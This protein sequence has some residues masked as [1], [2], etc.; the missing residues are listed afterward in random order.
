MYIP[1]LSIPSIYATCVY[2]FKVNHLLLD[3]QLLSSSLE[4]TVSPIQS[5]P[6]LSS[7]LCAELK[8]YKIFMI[9]YLTEMARISV[10]FDLYFLVVKDIKHLLPSLP[11]IL[12]FHLENVHMFLL[13]F[14]YQFIYFLDIVFLGD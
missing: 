2:I 10:C 1:K 8:P 14:I 12:F 9:N 11:S 13:I 5:V 7:I 6:Y 4:N 3:N